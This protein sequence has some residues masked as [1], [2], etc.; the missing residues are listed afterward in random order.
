MKKSLFT[1]RNLCVAAIIAAFYA[2]LT[3][4]TPWDVHGPVQLRVSEALTI[5]PIFNVAA[6]PGLF[7]GVLISNLIGGYGGLFG[8]FDMIFGSLATLL[9]AISTYYISRKL[10]LSNAKSFGHKILIFLAAM[11]PPIIFNAVIVG[12]YL[13]IFDIYPFAVYLTMMAV[14]AG[15]I[16]ACYGLGGILYF[17]LKKSKIILK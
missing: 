17:S 6:I 1:T 10:D 14:G 5:L 9:A 12:W 8:M 3:F 4:I 16:I 2:A 15:Q 7:V 11:F 13:Y